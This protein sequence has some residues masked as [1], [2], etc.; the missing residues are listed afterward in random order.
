MDSKIHNPKDM[1]NGMQTFLSDLEAPDPVQ[2]VVYSPYGME[3][4][5][6]RRG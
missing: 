1:K 3:Y 2:P 4:G 6:E 5:Y